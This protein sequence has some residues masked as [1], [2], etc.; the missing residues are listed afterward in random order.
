MNAFLR[1]FATVSLITLT[2]SIP[3]FSGEIHDAAK[4]GDLAKAKALLKDNPDLVSSKDNEGGTHFYEACSRPSNIAD[5]LFALFGDESTDGVTPLH[6]AAAQGNKDVV[7]L[8]LSHGA[9]VNAKDNKLG[10]TPLHWA[11]RADNK[12]VAELLLSHGADVNAKN[13]HGETP[14]HKAD[15]KDVVEL[16]LSHGADVNAKSNQNYTPLSRA[17][18][19]NYKD[20]IDLLRQHGGH[21]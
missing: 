15:N 14:L 7:E 2:W 6:K 16:L 18:A 11:V 1:R 17:L 5:M 4:A 21:E 3:A 8:L 20:I 12:D 19:W 13:K 10:Y 9:D